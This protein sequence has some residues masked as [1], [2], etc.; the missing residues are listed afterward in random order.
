[1]THAPPG[2]YRARPLEVHAIDLGDGRFVLLTEPPRYMST[3]NF[4]AGFDLV[5]EKRVAPRRSA[6]EGLAMLAAGKTPAEVASKL[7][8]S[9]SAVYLWRKSAGARP[10]PGA[11]QKPEAGA[12]KRCRHCGQMTSTDGKWCVHCMENP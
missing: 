6:T 7:K 11:H 10:N 8:V 9:R 3:E 4:A 2:L 12:M 1:M 5:E